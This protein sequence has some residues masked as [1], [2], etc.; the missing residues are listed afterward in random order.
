[1]VNSGVKF[2]HLQCF[3]AVAQQRSLQKAAASLS[4]T[5]PAV[6]K[7]LKELEELLQVRLFER[8]RKNATLTP[9]AQTFF[10]Y[11]AAS[12]S[13]MQQGVES[14]TRVRSHARSVISLGAPPTLA[15]SFLP[16]V[17]QR[18][19][20]HTGDIQ[21]NLQTGRNADLL[22]DLRD[23]KLD[24]MLGRHLDPK[25][26]VG[27][28][29]EHLYADPLIVVVRPGHP[30][31]GAAAVDPKQVGDY[32]AVLPSRGTFIRHVADTFA[33][34]EGIATAAQSIETL[35]VS[36]GRTY[37]HDSDAIW[38]VPWS[39]VVNDLRSGF[40]VKLPLAARPG[41]PASAQRMRSIGL[42]TRTDDLPAPEMQA[43]IDIIKEVADAG[44][45]E[46][47][48]L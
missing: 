12:V 34:E 10:R 36:F 47:T 20:A 30:L 48:M 22:S 7:T 31:L 38:F 25:R 21:V 3:L 23:R 2:R 4:I 41:G 1:M 35:S 42:L 16:A 40:L 6:S 19:V 33:V 15:P 32:P 11:A 13:A 37:T 45:L 24:I 27:I 17:L 43:L 8:G 46:A 14:M 18:F 44:E 26:M 9:E 39:A 5:Q 29:F 28:S